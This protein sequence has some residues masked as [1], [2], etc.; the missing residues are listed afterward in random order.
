MRLRILGG[1]RV[2][3]CLGRLVVRGGMSRLARFTTLNASIPIPP[4]LALRW[5]RMSRRRMGRDTA[6]LLRIPVPVGR[7]AALVGGR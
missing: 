1:L 2:V 5:G 7:R 4:I 3:R 6:R